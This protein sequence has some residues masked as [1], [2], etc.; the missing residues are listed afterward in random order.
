MHQYDSSRQST[1]YCRYFF[2][3]LNDHFFSQSSLYFRRGQSARGQNCHADPPTRKRRRQSQKWPE[4]RTMSSRAGVWLIMQCHSRKVEHYYLSNGLFHCRRR[5]NSEMLKSCKLSEGH[6][7]FKLSASQMI[8][9]LKTTNLPTEKFNVCRYRRD[10]LIDPTCSCPT[11]ITAQITSSGLTD[12]D[13]Y[14][15]SDRPG[16]SSCFSSQ[17]ERKD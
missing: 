11:C 17:I 3:I 7:R 9:S 1:A 4:V 10:I 2:Q 15:Y 16:Q 5:N 12:R 6:A 8:T 13:K 14:A